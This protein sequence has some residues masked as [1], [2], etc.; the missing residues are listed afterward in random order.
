MLPLTHERPRHI[1]SCARSNHRTAV[2][3]GQYFFISDV[4]TAPRLWS[5]AGIEVN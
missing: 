4:G 2:T 1:L 3:I 5:D